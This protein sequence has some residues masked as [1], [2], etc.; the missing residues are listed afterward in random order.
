MNI[1]IFSDL[2]CPWCFIGKRRLDLALASGAGKGVNVVWRAFQLYPGLPDEGMDRE[3][4]LRL[5]YGGSG[6]PPSR[7]GIEAEAARVSIQMR[8]DKIGRM[9]NTFK[10]HRL[11]HRARAD[12]VQHALAD[13]LFSAYFEQG[14]DVGSDAVLVELAEQHGLD[15]QETARFLASDESG[16][17]VQAELE[18]AANIGISAVPC[19][20]FAGAFA[21]PG[22]QE[23]E[24]IAQVIERARERLATTV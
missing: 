20:L 4:F 15:P 8:F 3:A 13:S 1:E 12:G 18:R 17:E 14:R 22:A 2:I 11:L 19:Y 5:R 10:G 23:P 6:R 16:E 21:L 7:S 24:V 9:P